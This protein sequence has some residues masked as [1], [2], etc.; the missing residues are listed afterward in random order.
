M[1]MHGKASRPW[2]LD[3][4]EEIVHGSEDGP[5]ISDLQIAA[6]RMEQAKADLCPR[7]PPTP[8]VRP[9]GGLPLTPTTG[10]GGAKTGAVAKTGTAALQPF[11]NAGARHAQMD[12]YQS[13]PSGLMARVEADLVQNMGTPPPTTMTRTPLSRTG[14]PR[15]PIK[16]IGKSPLPK[17]AMPSKA[18]TEQLQAK[19]EAAMTEL[20]A[21]HGGEMHQHIPI[22]DDDEGLEVVS[23]PDGGQMSLQAME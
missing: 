12:P 18:I 3:P 17:P 2:G 21:S 22:P 14:K 10:K 9:V 7:L 20:A 16:K 4:W 11:Y 8:Q 6:G 13:S 23:G 19:R 1:A 15:V 5:A